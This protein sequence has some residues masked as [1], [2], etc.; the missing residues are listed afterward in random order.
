MARQSSPNPSGSRDSE[1]RSRLPT[2]GCLMAVSKP[3]EAF[4]GTAVYTVPRWMGRAANAPYPAPPCFLRTVKAEVST[5]WSFSHFENVMGTKSAGSC[6][7]VAVK[8]SI[9]A[10]KHNI[11][12]NVLRSASV[13]GT[14]RDPTVASSLAMLR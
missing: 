2:R 14:G 12:A 7:C 1:L 4:I 10:V 5:P 9:M 11:L 3:I 13:P 6:D 8:H